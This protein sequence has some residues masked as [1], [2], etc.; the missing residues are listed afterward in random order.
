MALLLAACTNST[1]AP[2]SVASAA[3]ATP[4]PTLT[5]ILEATPTVSQ[6]TVPVAFRNGRVVCSERIV[7][8]VESQIFSYAAD[9]GDR[10]QL[11]SAGY[12][13]MPSWSRDGTRILFTSN[14][15]GGA[16][17]I[18][19]MDPDS[20]N[21]RQ[22]TFGTRGGNFTPVESPDGSYIA[23][24]GLRTDI[25]HPEVWVMNSDGSN[26]RRLTRTIAHP[27]QQNI[28]SL[29]P[30][31][32]PDGSK[33]AYASTSSGTTQIWIVNSDGSSPEQLTDGLGPEYPHANVPNWSL[34]GKRLTFWAGFERQYGEVWTINPDGSDVQRVTDTPDPTNS[35]DP[36]WSP[37]GEKI[38]FGRGM[39]GDRA[40][41]TTNAKGGE[42]TPFASGVHWCSWQPIPIAQ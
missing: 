5:P 1:N 28:W 30:S 17:E 8:G 33:I 41:W 11:T 15:G 24:S 37:D 26:P 22:L 12:N 27:G 7:G 4:G 6:T 42:A 14:L 31:W 39:Q 25:G 13:I 32:S 3:T 23:F 21:K 10:Q 40:M 18:W 9:G 2:T 19:L 16:M 20:G 38:I 35:D 34:D 36:H 29:H